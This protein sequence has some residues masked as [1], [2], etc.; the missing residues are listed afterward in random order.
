MK[1]ILVNNEF[2]SYN[3]FILFQGNDRVTPKYWWFQN[4]EKIFNM[5][6]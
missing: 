4:F 5:V 3:L 1:F 2:P 6:P